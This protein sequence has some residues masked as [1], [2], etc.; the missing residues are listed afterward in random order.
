VE[1]GLLIAGIVLL[2]LITGYYWG[3][4]LQAW[5]LSLVRAITSTPRP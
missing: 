1:Y 2:V 3:G 5:L 4:Q